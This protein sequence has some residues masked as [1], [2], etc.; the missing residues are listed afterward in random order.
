[1]IARV[2]DVKLIIHQI[3]TESANFNVIVNDINQGIRVKCIEI[4]DMGSTPFFNGQSMPRWVEK[5]P[6]IV[7]FIKDFSCVK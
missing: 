6:I 3:K 7:E 5:R 4:T 1:M 2:F